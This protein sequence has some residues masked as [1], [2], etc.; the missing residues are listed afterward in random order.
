MSGY[1]LEPFPE[2]YPNYCHLPECG[3]EEIKAMTEKGQ[4][5]TT[6]RKGF[7]PEYSLSLKG[8][9]FQA[10]DQPATTEPVHKI[11]SLQD[12][13]YAC[14]MGSAQNDNVHWILIFR[15]P[16]LRGATDL[17]SQI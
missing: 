2:H 5:P 9:R 8:Q 10:S 16:K 4:L 14:S 6:L 1:R 15:V 11:P 7:S 17:C 12:G 3:I 13:R